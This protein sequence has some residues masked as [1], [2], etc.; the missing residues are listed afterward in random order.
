MRD[1]TDKPNSDH[2]DIDAWLRALRGEG[3]DAERTE[4]GDTIRRTVLAQQAAAERSIDDDRLHHGKQRLLFRLAQDRTFD[5]RGRHRSRFAFAA[6][7]AVAAMLVVL[8]DTSV[9]DPGHDP[10]LLM[11]YGEVDRMRGATPDAVEVATSQPDADAREI[12]K[13]LEALD[14]PYELR[15]DERDPS[16][17]VLRIQ[18]DGIAN[19]EQVEAL[20][21]GMGI[22][23]PN[24]SV[25]V[26]RWVISQ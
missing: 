17:R 16:A 26:L 11:A 2:E 9:I 14:V 21:L 22:D 15:V 5:D 12:A 20:L 25:I 4:S 3:E 8:T 1:N 23:V 7:I 10:A 24:E 19:Y 18:F 6:S 13:Q